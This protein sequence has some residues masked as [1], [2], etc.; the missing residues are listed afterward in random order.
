MPRKLVIFSRRGPINKFNIILDSTVALLYDINEG[1][2][3]T[4]EVP[5]ILSPP[6]LICYIRRLIRY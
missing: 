6:G 1:V 3:Q 5:H 2:Q 4:G